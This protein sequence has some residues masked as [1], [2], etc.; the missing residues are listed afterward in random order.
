T[1]VGDPIQLRQ[2]LDNLLGNAI[3]YTPQGGEIKLTAI[4]E[5]G[6]FIFQ[7]IDSGIGI[8]T[9][10][11]KRIF[12]RFFRAT[13]APGD[14]QGTGLGLAIVKTIVDNHQGRIWVDS[15]LGKGSTFTVV[16]PIIADKTPED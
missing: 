4:E 5:D 14:I 7:V 6:Q 15:I 9:K 11:Q 16:L 10:D 1:V 13:N 3:K 2:M 12:D 8:P